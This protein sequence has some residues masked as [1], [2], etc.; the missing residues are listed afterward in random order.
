VA[1][2]HAHDD[3]RGRRQSDTIFFSLEV[4]INPFC[5]KKESSQFV[6]KC[7]VGFCENV[8]KHGKERKSEKKTL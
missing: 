4:E 1:A 5:K 6:H 7:I 2:L 8:F 3:G